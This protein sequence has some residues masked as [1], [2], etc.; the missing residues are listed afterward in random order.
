MT[1]GDDSAGRDEVREIG[2][3]DEGRLYVVPRSSTFPLIHREAM[4]VHWDESRSALYGPRP[5]E[6]SYV[7]WFRQILA[8]ARAQNCKLKLTPETTWVNIPDD[9]RAACETISAA[10][11]GR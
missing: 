4:E 8:A 10:N 1:V 3:D 11:D 9:L 6:W 2:I 5:R 7:D